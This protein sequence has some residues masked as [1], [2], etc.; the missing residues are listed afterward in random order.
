MN[1]D[2]K[3]KKNFALLY[4]RTWRERFS[5]VR[6]RS[7]WLDR[8]ACGIPALLSGTIRPRARYN[9]TGP[10]C[11]I[12]LTTDTDGEEGLGDG[13]FATRWVGPIFIHAATSWE[14]IGLWSPEPDIRSVL[15]TTGCK[16]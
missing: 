4:G 15:P 2:K 12:N 7:R 13:N 10:I 11:Q 1:N 9:V 14:G 5:A 8:R 16:P 3:Y 6:S